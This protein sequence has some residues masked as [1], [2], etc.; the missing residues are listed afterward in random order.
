M[1]VNLLEGREN[2]TEKKP[3]NSREKKENDKR[4]VFLRK[5]NESG[6]KGHCTSK[7]EVNIK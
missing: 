4:I 1:N 2:V 5:K 3:I 7:L 6:I